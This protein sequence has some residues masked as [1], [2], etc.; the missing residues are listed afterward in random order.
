M[1]RNK[2]DPTPA[3]RASGETMLDFAL[4]TIDLYFRVNAAGR[5]IGGF[6]EAGGTYGVLRTLEASG[7][8]TVPEIA[9]LRPVTRQ[10][11]QKLVNAMLKKGLV[12]LEPNPRHRRSQ[13]VAITDAGRAY[14]IETRTRFAAAAAAYA[15]TF[16]ESEIAGATEVLRRARERIVA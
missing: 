4:A 10:Y 11:I 14:Y 8:R 3:E 6:P 12:R 5:A 15:E 16:T 1:V 13:R 7:P 2:A 9:A